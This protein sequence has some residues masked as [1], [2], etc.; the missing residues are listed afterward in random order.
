MNEKLTII[1][2]LRATF[3]KISEEYQTI[4]PE[5]TFKVVPKADIPGSLLGLVYELPR[6][7]TRDPLIKAK[8]LEIGQLILVKRIYDGTIQPRVVTK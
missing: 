3:E 7:S 1:S 6:I 8:T 5:I 2:E 4:D